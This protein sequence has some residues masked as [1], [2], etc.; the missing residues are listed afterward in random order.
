MPTRSG[1][2]RPEF[3]AMPDD[4]TLREP[5]TD[6]GENAIT[7]WAEELAADAPALSSRQIA[8]LRRLFDVRNP[9]MRGQSL[10]VGEP[11]SARIAR[12]VRR[13]EPDA[14]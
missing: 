9:T 12:E 4:G 1:H 5:N 6:A 14:G 10:P 13:I 3:P 11:V 2:C 8:R 7:E